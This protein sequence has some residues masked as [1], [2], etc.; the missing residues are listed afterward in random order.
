VSKIA[1]MFPGQGSLEA[2]MGRDIAEAVPEAMAV[3]DVGS[4]ASGLDLRRLCF[5]SS[6]D[7]LVHTVREAVGGAFGADPGD[8][9]PLHDHRGGEGVGGAVYFPAAQEHGAVGLGLTHA[10][11]FPCRARW[12]APRGCQIRG[13]RASYGVERTTV[14]R[15]ETPASERRR[16]SSSSSSW[17][18]ATRTLRM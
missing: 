11:S 10:D 14:V 9:A 5:E 8:M 13:G 2:G 3:Y 6:V 12:A 7:D 16:A 18:V 17:G 4:E 1:F 15:V